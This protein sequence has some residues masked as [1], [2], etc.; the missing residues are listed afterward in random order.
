[1]FTTPVTEL[2]SG[3]EGKLV[4][5]HWFWV[6]TLSWFMLGQDSLGSL[7]FHTLGVGE[8]VCCGSGSEVFWLWLH[9]SSSCRALLG[10][11][12]LYSSE[13]MSHQ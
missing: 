13:M 1:M 7:G 3:Q 9:G 5:A 8:H 10:E 2:G 4:S 12:C 6:R 11:G